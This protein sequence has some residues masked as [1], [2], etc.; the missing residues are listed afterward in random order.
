MEEPPWTGQ[1][2]FPGY[3]CELKRGKDIHT[4]AVW[5]QRAPGLS[6]CLLTPLRECTF[7][8]CAQINSPFLKLQF[9]LAT[10]EETTNLNTI[11][12]FVLWV[13][14][15]LCS[16]ACL[17]LVILCPASWDYI[18]MAQCLA[19]LYISLRENLFKTLQRRKGKAIRKNW[20]CYWAKIS[21]ENDDRSIHCKPMP[22]TYVLMNTDNFLTASGFGNRWLSCT[23]HPDSALESCTLSI[24]ILPSHSLWSIATIITFMFVMSHSFS[25]LLPQ[26]LIFQPPAAVSW[27]VLEKGK[28]SRIVQ[29]AQIKHI[30]HRT[31]RMQDCGCGSGEG[32]CLAYTLPGSD[33][34]HHTHWVWWWW[35][36]GDQ[37]WKAILGSSV[38][39]R[40]RQTNQPSNHHHQSHYKWDLGS[41]TS[42]GN[43]QAAVHCT[44]HWQGHL[45]SVE[46]KI[47]TRK[48]TVSDGWENFRPRQLRK[49][50][51][52]INW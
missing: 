13:R 37:E 45:V 38:D 2:H 27:V 23:D 15:P 29:P 10:W 43:T 16:P 20:Y 31:W 40:H 1:H 5:F 48:D 51:S 12:G 11:F 6:F 22:C 47:Q 50:A 36:Q 39:L 3:C 44:H 18:H 24:T 41:G 25:C 46:H 35:R 33:P 9:F 19:E 17:L 26:A 7:T 4:A 14:V 30:N 28:F 32:A 8:L 49:G 52:C 21:Q 34:Q 42:S